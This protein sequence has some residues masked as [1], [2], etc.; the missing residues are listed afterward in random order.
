MP[1]RARAK[2][3]RGGET[4]RFAKIPVSVLESIAVTTLNHAAFRI[5]TI[6]AAGYWGGNNGALALTPAYARRYGL[7][8]RQTI[9]DSLKELEARGLIECT[10]RG[11]KVKN[12]FT[13][14]ALGWM[15]INNRN[16]LP[17]QRS[18]SAPN[19]WIKWRDSTAD[20][21][22]NTTKIQTDAQSQSV[23]DISTIT[24]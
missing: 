8:S 22:G 9:Y 17:L 20:G 18:E 13:L 15:P 4:E 23:P 10:R 2:G 5:L 11:M 21:A 19:A 14:Y 16:G 12:I 7:T 6:L 1:N 24:H 3:R